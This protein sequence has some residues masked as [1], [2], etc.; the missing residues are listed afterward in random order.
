[1]FRTKLGDTVT[2]PMYY[3]A[4]RVPAEVIA[5][6][7]RAGVAECE[8]GGPNGVLLRKEYSLLVLVP[9]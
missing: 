7:L 3:G 9:A 5:I 8:I 4:L 1:M 6:D 2:V